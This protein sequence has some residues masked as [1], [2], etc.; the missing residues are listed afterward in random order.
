MVDFA[1]TEFVGIAMFEPF[2]PFISGFLD[3]VP[4]LSQIECV[5]GRPR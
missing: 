4:Q 2:Q 5:P 3:N 1:A